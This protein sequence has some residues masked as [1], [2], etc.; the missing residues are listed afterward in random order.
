M[1]WTVTY[2]ASPEAKVKRT[3]SHAVN[4]DRHLGRAPDLAAGFDFGHRN[5]NIDLARSGMNKSFVNDGNGGFREPVVTKDP[6]GKDRPP[7]AEF[8]DYRDTRVAQ[9][10]KSLRKDAVI[11][12]GVMLQLDPKWFDAHCPDW[13][14]DGLNDEA[15]RF[16]QTQLDWACQE[17]GQQNIVGGSLDLDETSPHLQLSVVPVTEDCRLSQKD[18]FRGPGHFKK[19]RKELC[20]ALEAAGYDPQRSVSDRSTERTSSAEYARTADKTRA[21]LAVAQRDSRKLWEERQ[22]LRAEKAKLDV[23]ARAIKD[24]RHQLDA[25]LQDLPRLR[26][27]AIDD[28]LEA[29]RTAARQETAEAREAARAAERRAAEAERRHSA[30]VRDLLAL[31]A[32]IQQ[33]LVTTPGPPTY[34]EMRQDILGAQPQLLAKFLRGMKLKD[35]STLEDKFEEFQRRSFAAYQRRGSDA[36]GRYNGPSYEQWKGRGLE[37]Q[38][39][40]DAA[41]FSNQVADMN[42]PPESPSK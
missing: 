5:P 17:F 7:S 1:S 38:R 23:E 29:A 10:K 41:S 24:D 22:Q 26:R 34:E 2:D 37:M 18:F 11:M 6:K 42:G 21:T 31:R 8:A 28:G 33:Q 3:G 35:G 40:I 27:R 15:H 16:V 13:R 12:R 9:V 39:K 30:A 25:Q 20:D 32:Q 4:R 19:Q 14:T 36:L